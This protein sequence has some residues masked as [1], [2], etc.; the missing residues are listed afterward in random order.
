MSI[1]AI[2]SESRLC[3][4][5][6]LASQQ[7]MEGHMS[8]ENLSRRAIVAGAASVPALALPAVAVDVI[9]N[10]DAELVSLSE[11]LARLWPAFAAA[12]DEANTKNEAT[13]KLLRQRFGGA[14][15]SFPEETYLAEAEKADAETGADIA[16]EKYEPLQARIFDIKER[17]ARLLAR[18]LVGLRAKAVLAINEHDD[19]WKEPAEDLDWDKQVTRALIEAVCAVT[20]VGVPAESLVQS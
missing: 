7:P 20:G 1:S 15:D 11:D 18:P 16:N 10:P 14:F 13:T 2:Y 6:L 17:L 5:V 9:G 4:S 19:L 3:E 12:R 8:P